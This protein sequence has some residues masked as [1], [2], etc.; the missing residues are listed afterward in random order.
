MT[1]STNLFRHVSETKEFS[2]GSK[3][4]SIGEY[5]QEMY[6]VIEGEVDLVDY[7]EKLIETVGVGGMFGELAL[8]D[9]KPH[10]LTAI[11][12]TDCKLA[13]VNYDRFIFMVVETPYFAL[14]VMQVLAD[15]LRRRINN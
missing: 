3:I 13:P 5:G 6:V 15:R 7:Q 1:V 2:A 14:H 9:S 4:F 10:S 12:K 11:A 8:I